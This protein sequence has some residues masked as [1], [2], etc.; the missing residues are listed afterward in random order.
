MEEII[1]E[2][3]GEFDQKVMQEYEQILLLDAE[4]L[5]LVGGGDLASGVIEIPK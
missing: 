4:L 1:L 3:K 2:S 5:S